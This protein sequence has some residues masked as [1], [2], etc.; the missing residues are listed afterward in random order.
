MGPG[1]P[2][3][4]TGGPGHI[5]WGPGHVAV[6]ALRNTDAP[7]AHGT[8]LSGLHSGGMHHSFSYGSP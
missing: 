6:W 5:T 2:G 3:H 1:V 8:D 7:G 4:V